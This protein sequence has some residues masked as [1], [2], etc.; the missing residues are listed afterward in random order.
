MGYNLSLVANLTTICPLVT[1]LGLIP[2]FTAPAAITAA[3]R[4]A[5]LVAI[6]D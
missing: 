2:V 6:T 1:S 3:A 5:A 4:L